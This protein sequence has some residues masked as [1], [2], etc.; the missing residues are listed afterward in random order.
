MNTTSP[1]ATL[2]V[3]RLIKAP[4]ERVFAAWT[5][6]D[7]VMKWFGPATCQALSVKIDLRVGGA[8]HVRVKTETFGELDVRGVYREVKAPSRLVYT[9]SWQGNAMMEFGES[10]V[11]VDFLDKDG[12]TEIQI[13]HD[14]LPSAEH[15]ENHGEGWNGCLDKLEK[16]LSGCQGQPP[17]P[18]NF[19]WNELITSDVAAAG[20]FYGGLFGWKTEAMPMPGMNYTLFKQGDKSIGGMMAPMQGGVPPH[21]LPYV[22]VSDADGC[23]RLAGQ[24]GGKVILPPFDVPEVGRIAVFQDPQGATVGILQPA[25]K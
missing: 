14:L 6:P 18:G 21:W 8:Y 5:N 11:T 10:V 17:A 20:G 1:D 12:A 15:R 16:Q 7:E 24:L 23:A 3:T 4:R 13:T 19:I 25:G 22:T 9:W 2:R